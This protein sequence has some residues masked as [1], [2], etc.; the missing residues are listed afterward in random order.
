MTQWIKDHKR[1][2]IVG[3]LGLLAGVIAGE[4]EAK[5]ALVVAIRGVAALL[6]GAS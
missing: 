2:L 5:E 4:M 6:G 3:G 1:D